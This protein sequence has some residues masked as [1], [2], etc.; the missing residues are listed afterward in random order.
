MLRTQ[1]R[2][3]RDDCLSAIVHPVD[4]CRFSDLLGS[5]PPRQSDK[6]FRIVSD[7]IYDSMS[8][9]RELFSFIDTPQ[10]QR[11]R[12]LKQ[13]GACHLVY[14]GA[15]HTRFEHSLGVAYLSKIAF[16]NLVMKS[17]VSVTDVEVQRLVRL[18]QIAG[19]CHD[20]GHGPYSH[21]FEHAFVHRHLGLK[22]WCHEDM[23]LK[24]FEY[25][26]DNNTTAGE[27]ID[28][29]NGRTT[30]KEMI[31]GIDPTQHRVVGDHPI[32]ALER[33]AYDIVN[34]KRNGLD[35]D[36]M[37]YLQRDAST[38]PNSL[39]KY[40]P[41]R[42]L[43]FATVM[44][45]G[46]ICYNS[47][48]V[49]AVAE[50]VQTRFRLFKILYTHRKTLAFE[51]MKTDALFQASK[52]LGLRRIIEEKDCEG[53]LHLTDNIDDIIRQ[54]QDS[55]CDPGIQRAKELF[56]R[57]DC[58]NIYRF[59]AEYVFDKKEDIQLC[60]NLGVDELNELIA[61]GAGVCPSDIVVDM[62]KIHHGSKDKN[63][64]DFVGFY[65]ETAGEGG[66]PYAVKIEGEAEK[67]NLISGAHTKSRWQELRLLVLIKE[68][69]ENKFDAVQ[70][71][72]NSILRH[73]L[74]VTD[75]M[76]VGQRT[77][78][79]ATPHQRT[80]EIG[81]LPLHPH[82]QEQRPTDLLPPVRTHDGQ[83]RQASS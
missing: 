73:K 7:R 35:T 63:P 19:V 65:T 53:Y 44:P 12:R 25:L 48:E 9:D 72:F 30:V 67:R 37:D 54:R 5:I 2:Q 57:I 70:N 8:F 22:E 40:N 20:L 34:N 66:V 62:S 47:K 71:A 15:V 31:E 29:L 4:R 58:R 18:L 42:L 82:A 10:V 26:I 75:A 49:P 51:A 39:P 13:L 81:R 79:S 74:H 17:G 14:P 80:P 33:A 83:F 55:F 23:S 28:A 11:L 3:D 1:S 52:A 64:L 60:E 76:V 68:Q 50:L 45:D 77:P 56:R 43:R 69:D 6:T 38:S 78:M 41:G 27:V 16:E 61:K 36:K 59:V 21:T 32:F 46:E 24:L